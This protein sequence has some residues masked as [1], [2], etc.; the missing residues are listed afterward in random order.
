MVGHIHLSNVAQLHYKTPK[1]LHY[2]WGLPYFRLPSQL[3]G[4]QKPFS[5]YFRFFSGDI[6]NQ[7]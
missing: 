6:F 3:I 1:M 7:V 2:K 4:K 5:E